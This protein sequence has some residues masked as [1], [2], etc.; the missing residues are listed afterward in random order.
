MKRLNLA[1]L[2]ALVVAALLCGCHLKKNTPLDATL[3]DNTY[4]NRFFGLQV[5]LPSTWKIM[6]KPSKREMRKGAE[7][8]LGGDKEL[9]KAAAA[10]DVNSLLMAVDLSTGR[11]LGLAA[12]NLAG[13]GE[14]RTGADYLNA[15]LDVM[16]GPDRPLQKV[17]SMTTVK[18]PSKE[19]Q[20]VDVAGDV[21]GARQHQAIFVTVEKGY[22]LTL[23]LGG[24]SG[25]DA[26]DVLT[27]VGLVRG[28]ATPSKDTGASDAAW[29]NGIKLQGIGGTEARPF[30][31]I[32][33]RTLEAGEAG[34]VK[35]AKTNVL[36][37]CVAISNASVVVMIEG[38]KG[39]RKLYLN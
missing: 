17:S 15:M 29:V 13:A 20:R 32:N 39:E 16:T 5:Q 9:A 3:K 27:K 25:A 22:A 31:I 23:I 28:Q 1:V 26:D 10:A 36:V 12:E 2:L 4:T 30:A 24:K 33:G 6:D 35:T 38:L 7:A 34:R 11:T 19:F 14:I 8:I 18:F 21:M 37:R